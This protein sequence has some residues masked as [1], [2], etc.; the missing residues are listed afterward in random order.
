MTL[1]ETF[2]QLDWDKIASFVEQKQEENLHLDFKT[3]ANSELNSKDDKRNLARSVS[4]FANS[5]GGIV[6]WGID[7]RENAD[8]IDCATSIIELT[9]PAMMVSRLNTLTGD[10]TS[11]TVDGIRHKAIINPATGHG[12]VATLVPETDSGPF[13][14]KLGE[15]RYFKRS[16]DSF[17]QM[18]HFDLADMFGRRQKPKLEI[19]SEIAKTKIEI[20]AENE[21]EVITLRLL[22]TG[23]AVARHSGFVLRLQNVEITGT[24]G[25]L[26]NIS[27]INAGRPV[28]QYSNEMG[29][30]HP[31]G[32]RINVG[33]ISVRRKDAG[34]H[35]KGDLT[36]YCEGMQA[37]DR[38]IDIPPFT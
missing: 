16:G 33:S 11:P 27:S 32:I 25:N 31:N 1:T 24:G 20:E 3:V 8:S 23:R 34:A 5:S 18:E 10:A 12:V 2:D 38:T 7:A 15:N 37:F 21:I 30:V 13:M 28:V 26:E 4:G 6:V 36:I 22:N 19:L 35:I 29:V 9:K 14:A 17:Y